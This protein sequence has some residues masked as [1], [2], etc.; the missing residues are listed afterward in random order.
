M[1]ATS[2]APEVE[3]VGAIFLALTWIS[4]GMRCYVK[5]FMTKSFAVEDWLAICAQV[6]FDHVKI[7]NI[8]IR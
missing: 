4:T 3:T 6:C 7:N 8:T 1:V 5:S 2:R